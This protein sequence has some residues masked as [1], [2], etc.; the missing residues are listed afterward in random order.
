LKRKKIWPIRSWST[1]VYKFPRL[2]HSRQKSF[3][4]EIYDP[5]TVFVCEGINE[6]KQRIK[7]AAVN[8]GKCGVETDQIVYADGF[9]I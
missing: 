1:T 6:R 9:E 3:C 8:L 4:S 2:V 5:L 7:L